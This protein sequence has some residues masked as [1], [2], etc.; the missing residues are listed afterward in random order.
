[1][2]HDMGIKSWGQNFFVSL[3]I[4]TSFYFQLTWLTELVLTYTRM[5]WPFKLGITSWFWRSHSK[6]S[7]FMTWYF[8]TSCSLALSVFSPCR[9]SAGTLAKAP[10]EGASKVKGPATWRYQLFVIRLA[11]LNWIPFQHRFH[12]LFHII[13]PIK[14][15]HLF[16][17]H[18]VNWNPRNNK[19][20]RKTFTCV[21]SLSR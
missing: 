7:P 9:A 12:K 14:H 4:F 20:C 3:L 6:I 1:M 15:L 21:I 10:S 16:L 8:N 5:E 13:Y 17:E 2:K 19:V 11:E 18:L